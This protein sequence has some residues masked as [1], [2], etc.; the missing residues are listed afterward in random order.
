MEDS[1]G[2][3]K[4]VSLDNPSYLYSLS[5]NDLKDILRERNSKVSGTKSELG[6]ICGLDHK[7]DNR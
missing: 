7:A 4:G 2:S 1:D 6:L 5:V 3:K